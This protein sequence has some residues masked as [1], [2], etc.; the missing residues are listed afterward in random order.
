LPP[1]TEPVAEAAAELPPS[2]EARPAPPEEAPAAFA[3]Q[4]ETAPAETVPTA[5]TPSPGEPE[6]VYRIQV[7]ASHR[8]YKSTDPLFQPLQGEDLYRAQ[9]GNLYKYMVGRFAT[10][11]EAE[12]KQAELRERGYHDC[13]IVTQRFAVLAAQ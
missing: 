8:K 11:P 10:R 5:A 1:V 13:F 12:A 7:Y 9:E 6:T 4:A 2:G 3:E